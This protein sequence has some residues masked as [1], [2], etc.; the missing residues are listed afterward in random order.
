MVTRS[1][2]GIFKPKHPITLTATT[3]DLLSSEPK[4]PVEALKHPVWK[5]AMQEEYDALMNQG[6]WIL[7]P[8][9]AHVNVI[10]CQWIF[11]IK[12]HSDGTIAR[13]KARLVANGNQ[14]FAGLDFTETFS[15]VIKQPTLR[16][17]LALAVSKNWSLRQL[18][19]SNAFLHGVL[20]ETVYMRQPPGYSHSAY[21]G[22][23]C[24][25]KKSLYGLRQAP[26]AWYSMLSKFLVDHGFHQSKAD[27]SLFIQHTGSHLLLI[28]VY[29]DDIIITGS[30]STVITSVISQLSS[31][32]AIKD[33]GDLH[34]FS[35]N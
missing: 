26:R 12:K 32:F 2:L 34:F 14:Q 5:A 3:T 16:L 25:L 10:G 1:K 9:P 15:P 28:L 35:W 23:V 27:N 33:L 7:V 4:S 19:V 18:D 30:D 13:Y 31:A 8:R 6:T 11:K 29:V 24:Q 22:Y 21:P 17:V 20:D